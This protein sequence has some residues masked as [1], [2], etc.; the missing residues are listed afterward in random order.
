MLP[1]KKFSGD[2]P[3]S[4]SVQSVSGDIDL[5][6]INAT[7]LSSVE[8]CKLKS[9]SG[10]LFLPDG[11][12][13]SLVASTVSGNILAGS[14]AARSVEVK[15]T[16]GD[17]RFDSVTGLINAKTVSGNISA[18]IAEISGRI[19]LHTVSGDIDLNI[20]ADSDI[21]VSFSTVSGD[22]RTDAPIETTQSHDKGV[23]GTLGTGKHPVTIAT[24]SGNVRLY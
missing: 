15:T 17:I 3:S 6:N 13:D 2:R 9:V 7:G 19:D 18:R 12:Y 14:T 24:T 11:Q 20:P 5:R 8:S 1:A 22:F 23:E 4:L 10:D 21:S 16:S